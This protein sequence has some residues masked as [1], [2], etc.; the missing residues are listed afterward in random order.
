[1]KLLDKGFIDARPFNF[2]PLSEL[3]LD[4]DRRVTLI[5]GRVINEKR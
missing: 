4:T 1:M 2:I 5:Y 3:L